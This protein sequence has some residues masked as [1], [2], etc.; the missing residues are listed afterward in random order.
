MSENY[1]AKEH[2]GKRLDGEPDKRLSSEHGF[3]GG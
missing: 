1:S 2:D 3:G